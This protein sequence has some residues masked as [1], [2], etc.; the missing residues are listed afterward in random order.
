ML[1]FG[2]GASKPLG[3]PTNREFFQEFLAAKPGLDTS[4]GGFPLE[5]DQVAKAALR[6]SGHP[7]Y[8]LEA[9]MTILTALSADQ[10]REALVTAGK[11]GVAFAEAVESQELEPQYF[12]ATARNK[13]AGLLKQVK[14]YIRFRCQNIDSSKLRANF[15]PILAAFSGKDQTG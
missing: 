4:L 15:D 2:A 8:D 12:V 7:T 5:F 3:I 13:A 6:T 10:P 9:V 1:F 11:A 14:R